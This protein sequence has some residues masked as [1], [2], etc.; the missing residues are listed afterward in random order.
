VSDVFALHKPVVDDT[1]HLAAHVL[2][3]CSALRRRSGLHCA[4]VV[5]I[6]SLYRL[7]CVTS[8]SESSSKWC[9]VLMM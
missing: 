9:C 4:Y 2:F 1:I 7:C 8:R 3:T 5:F 6:G